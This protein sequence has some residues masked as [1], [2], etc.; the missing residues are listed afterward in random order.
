MRKFVIRCKAC[1][2]IDIAFDHDF[3]Y[4]TLVCEQCGRREDVK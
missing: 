1:G 3:V 2:S 4:T